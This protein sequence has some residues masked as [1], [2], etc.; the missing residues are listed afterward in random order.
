MIIFR[1]IGKYRKI[2]SAHQKLRIFQLTIMMVVGG[3][4]EMLSVSL[5]LPFINAVMDPDGMMQNETV[6]WVCNLFQI[7]SYRTFLVLA[8]LV[9]AIAY[10]IKNVYLVLQT[11]VQYRFVYNNM[12]A[13]QARLLRSFL[14]RPYEYFLNVNSGEV[15]C[16]ITN[17][18]SET[19][20]L[21]ISVLAFFSEMIVSVALV[22]T[23]FVIAPV[24]TIGM[25]IILIVMVAIILMIIRPILSKA[26]IALQ[27]SSAKMNQWMMQSIQG[28]KELK[29]MHSEGFFEE[30]FE[31]YG[32]RTARSRYQNGTLSIVPRFLIEAISLSS[33]FIMVAV[34][35]YRGMELETLIP[36]LSAV[37]MA[38][39][40]LL[41]SANRIAQAMADIAYRESMLDKTIENLQDV[42]ES[43]GSKR[44]KQ[45]GNIKDLNQEIRMKDVY[46]QYPTGDRDILQDA[47]MTIKKGMSV[48]IVGA[49]GAGKTTAVDIL[50]GLLAPK[51]GSVL[52]DGTEIETDMMGWIS[53]IGYI[54]QSIFMLDG[55]IRDNVA[56]GVNKDDIDDG[57]VWEALKEAALDEYVKNLPEQLDTQ[58]GER[59]IRLSGGQR[60]RIGIAR[61]LYF[62]P[63]VLVFDEAT[64][65]LDNETE[66]AIM[67]SIHKLHGRKTMI[68]IAH[69]LSTI[70]NCDVVYRVEEKKIEVEREIV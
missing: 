58:I 44:I 55:S 34:M 23:I 59:G 1:V 3:L 6:I 35:I 63:S 11:G 20:T 32:Y 66:K 10:I 70:E 5:M 46:Y 51:K 17:D 41:P 27:D 21:L 68:I 2:L 61:A 69:R 9:L 40:R 64:S 37:A 36:M 14:S 18:T 4:L 29:I 13:V 54:P 22:A 39:I 53:N 42:V 7:E 60:Q 24:M 65:A 45:D 12:F 26:G 33:F 19:F 43:D 56:F 57:H 16:I 8:A 62:N 67:E 15:L 49:S 38:A 52:V 31:K 30:N 50:I 25:A 48:G 47:N 28:I